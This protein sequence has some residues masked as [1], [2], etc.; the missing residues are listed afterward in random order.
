MKKYQSA[1]WVALGLLL[2][3]GLAGDGIRVLEKTEEKPEQGLDMPETPAPPQEYGLYAGISRE[4]RYHLSAQDGRQGKKAPAMKRKDVYTFLQGPKSWEEKLPWSGEWCRFQVEGNP[5]GGFGCGL[6][7]M[8]NIYNTLSPYEVSPLDM[9]EY[10]KGVSDYAPAGEAGAIGWQDMADSLES[11]GFSVKLCRKP[12]AYK[13][14]QKQMSKVKSAI[15]LVSSSE[16]DTFWQDTPGHYVNI[17]LYR[18]KD[19]MVFLAEPGDPDRNRTW[20]PLRYVYDALKT[21]SQYHYLLVESY[22]EEENQWKADGIQIEWNRPK[23][24]TD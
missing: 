6:C 10:A 17:W 18:A 1:L 11:C 15:V 21:R 12:H 22:E 2:M 23:E 13:V 20:I 8:A 24:K 5:F 3:L 9:F 7:C 19:D 4:L 14:F 16:D